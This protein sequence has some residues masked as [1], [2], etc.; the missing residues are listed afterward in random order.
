M[1]NTLHITNGDT[2][3]E[4]L[5][6]T[7][8]TGDI[9]VWHEM[10]SVGPICK[11]V[12]GDEF[13]IKRYSFFEQEYQVSKLEYFDKT[14][15]E[16]LKIEDI[17]LNAEVVLWFEFDLFCQVNLMA[18]C[19][20]L[21]KNFRKDI[22]YNLICTG[23]VKGKEKLQSLSDYSVEQYPELYENRIKLS[24]ANLEYATKCWNM[25]VEN[26]IEELKEFNF[27]KVAKFQYFQL[28]I[29]Q[30]LKR[31]PAKNGL[32]EI[33]QKTLEIIN[34]ATFTEN[35]I[36]Q[37]LL[38]WQ[39]KETVYGFGGLQYFQYLKKL[40]N[41]YTILGSEYYLNENGRD[42]INVIVRN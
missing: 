29:N 28:A 34:S 25:Y 11:E 40:N 13:W 12:C 10:L 5:K 24:K 20:Y 16:I 33:Q 35:E 23:W 41:Y 37:Q 26:N 4:T 31:F 8:L 36:I 27:K 9:I 19:T 17:P 22:T 7:T 30:H 42:I 1:A 6:K 3:A 38:I 2:T 18:L 15:K 14:I 32:N 21:L 39:Q